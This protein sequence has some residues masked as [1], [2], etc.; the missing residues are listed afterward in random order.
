MIIGMHE[1][2]LYG[3]VEFYEEQ[4]DYDCYYFIFRIS[5]LSDKSSIL[6]IWTVM[7]VS[8]RVEISCLIL[9]FYHYYCRYL[10]RDVIKKN[11]ISGWVGP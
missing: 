8:G 6:M 7:S 2:L 5:C 9:W 4:Y 10:M 11:L 3:V 1:L